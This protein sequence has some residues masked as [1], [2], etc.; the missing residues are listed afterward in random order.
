[1]IWLFIMGLGVG[2]IFVPLVIRMLGIA[3]SIRPNYQGVAVPSCA[4]IAIVFSSIVVVFMGIAFHL[5]PTEAGASFLTL[6]L[7]M[8]FAGL[9][10]DLLGS[11][12]AGGF[13]GH[14]RLLLM[15][16]RLTTG[17]IK[18]IFGGLLALTVSLI[19]GGN[20]V[21]IL[22][23]GLLISLLAN[24]I[25][26]LDLRPGRALKTYL[27]GMLALFAAF[28]VKIGWAEASGMDGTSHA[29]GGAIF[30]LTGAA[31]AYL[32]WD[33]KARAMMGDV[34][35]NVLGAALGYVAALTLGTGP[36]VGLLAGLAVVHLY[37]EKGSLT[38]VIEG[39]VVLR[40][41]DKLGRGGQG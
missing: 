36:K 22:I 6:T 29:F 32:P 26:L 2:L 3:G 8:G 7:G 23:N 19:I 14:F 31:L 24:F 37:S 21:D 4:G 25:N 34:G 28:V 30:G 39:N 17:A 16:G 18:A 1:M 15:E 27:A 38:K 11:R 35:S 9:A 10:D 41:L 20:I 40:F 12:A 5:F 33:L 13:R